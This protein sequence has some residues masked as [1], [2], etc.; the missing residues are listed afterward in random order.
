MRPGTL[1]RWVAL[2][3]L[4]KSEIKDNSVILDIG[5]YDG[6]ISYRLK[7]MLP[8]LNI[9]VVDIDKTGLKLAREKGLD[10]FYASAL[11]LPIKDNQVDVVLC[12]DLIEH[13]KEDNRLVKETS[14][15][16]RK[17]GKVIL[18]T[19]MQNG[20]SF[21]FLSKERVE[22]INKG[23]GHVRKGYSLE[24]IKKLFENNSLLI[25]RKSS[26]FNL[27]TR[28]A[29]RFSVISKIPF[30]GESLL[31]RM[32]IKL[33]PYIRLGAQEHIII[34]VKRSVMTYE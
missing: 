30:K 6:E 34:G 16:L 27:L 17:D 10:T 13:V 18:T 28:L 31:Y 11:E 22:A 29:Y 8:K 5:G 24:S 32:V 7:N 15:V 21:P 19:P 25:E 20:V 33:E 23:W 26:Y 1:L 12:L 2:K 14:R 4:L 9:T 3:N